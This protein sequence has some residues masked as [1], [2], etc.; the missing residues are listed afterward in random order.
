MGDSS[1]LAIYLD[2]CLFI[3]LYVYLCSSAC[4]AVC[5]SVSLSVCLFFCPS[6]VCQYVSARDGLASH[7]SLYLYALA[8]VHVRVCAFYDW[9]LVSYL[10]FC[11]SYCNPPFCPPV[12]LSTALF[13][14]PH[15]HARVCLNNMTFMY[16]CLFII[17]VCRLFLPSVSPSVNLW[18][19]LISTACL[20]L[21]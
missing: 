9:L 18:A 5:L 19:Q 12:C 3:C 14:R 17:S 6:A 15:L 10:Y 8:Y 20:V 21:S 7:V 11:L 13:L 16:D 1:Y 4:L 2:I